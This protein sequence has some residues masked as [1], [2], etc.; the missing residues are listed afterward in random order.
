MFKRFPKNKKAID[1]IKNVSKKAISKSSDIKEPP[2]DQLQSLIN[3]YNQGLFQRALN[4]GSQLLKDFPNSI[5]LY[6]IIGASNKGLGKLEEAIEACNNALSIKPD[7][8]E[9][10]YNM[11]IALQDQGKLEEAIEACNK[12]LSLKPDY[13]EAYY[14]MGIAM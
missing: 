12:A 4:Q 10:Y 14:N 6:N 2:Q 11:G 1:V 8:A 5:N 9:A 7:Y 13:A 3:L